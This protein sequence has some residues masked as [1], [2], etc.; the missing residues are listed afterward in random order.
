[1][2]GDG[3][4]HDLARYRLVVQKAPIAL[5][6]RPVAAEPPQAS[7]ALGREAPPENP[8]PF[9]EPFVAELPQIRHALHCA[10]FR[11]SLVRQDGIRESQK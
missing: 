5:R 4:E 9:F 6:R 8:P 3:R 2:I 7:R 11:E 10:S 1:M